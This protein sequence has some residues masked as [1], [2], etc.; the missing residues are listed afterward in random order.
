MPRFSDVERWVDANWQLLIEQTERLELIQ[1][2]Y[3]EVVRGEQEPVRAFTESD[4]VI[5][6]AT[7]V[8][9]RRAVAHWTL[10]QEF[11][12]GFACRLHTDLRLRDA[13]AEA[14]S[15]APEEFYA[16]AADALADVLN[17][18]QY[19]PAISR[20]RSCAEP[21]PIS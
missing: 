19:D 13:V 15:L 1:E 20:S 17:M 5:T 18:N 2:R 3:G 8:R 21:S 12:A 4:Y 7:R 9:Q 14:V 11:A 16:K 10:Y 6:I